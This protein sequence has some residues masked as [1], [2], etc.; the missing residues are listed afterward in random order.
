MMYA[1][2]VPFSLG[3]ICGPALQGVMSGQVPKNEQ[4][5]LQGALTSLVSATAIF[6]PLMMTNLFSFF[7]SKKAPFYFPGASFFMGALLTL[8]GVLFAMRSLSKFSRHEKFHT[9]H[10]SDEPISKLA[11]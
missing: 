2:V 11:D 8:I 5:E 6:G 1:F 7:T 4:G 9:V 3:G 10:T